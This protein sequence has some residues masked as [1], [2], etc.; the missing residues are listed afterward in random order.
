MMLMNFDLFFMSLLAFVAVCNSTLDISS[1]QSSAEGVSSGFVPAQSVQDSSS[2]EVIDREVLEAGEVFLVQTRSKGVELLREAQVVTIAK[3]NHLYVVTV[4]DDAGEIVRVFEGFGGT[5]D[6][7]A[8]AVL[9][10]AEALQ[11][12]ESGGGI[13]EPLDS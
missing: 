8:T 4:E 12:L 2:D 7:I 10:E 13:V 3:R 5:S 1:A 11:L 6:L 9:S